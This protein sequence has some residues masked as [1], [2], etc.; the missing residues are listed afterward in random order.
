MR[1][2]Q[3]EAKKTIERIL[4][5]AGPGEWEVELSARTS[6]H[7]RF[8]RN[9]IG[10]SGFVEDVDLGVTARQDGRSGTVGTNDLSTAG[11]KAA[12]ARAAEMRDFMPVDPETVEMLP[13]Q[14]YPTLEKYDDATALARAADRAHGVKATLGLAQRRSLTSAGF[15]ENGVS[16][17][18]IGNS[19]GNFGYHLSTDAEF[20]VTMRTADGTGSGWAAGS[21]PRL[22]D[23]DAKSLARSAADKGVASAAPRDVPPG[24]YTVILEPAA[25]AALLQ[26]L[27]LG[28]LQARAA[29]EGRSVFSKQGGGSRVGEKVAH[30]SVTLRT[31]PFDAR[32]PGAPW[33]VRGGFG[34]GATDG[35]PN[36]RIAWIEKGVLK[37]LYAD[38]YWAGKTGVEATPFPG[39]LVLDGGKESLA[40]LIA[41]TERGLLVT[42]FWYIRTVNPQT[43][44]LTGLTR[45]GLFLIEKGK[46]THPATNLRF[47]ESPLVMLANV[48]G[49]TAAVPAGRMVVP[50]IRSR[51]FTFTSKSDAV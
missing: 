43:W 15:F 23:L 24:D 25:V 7:T 27:Q 11:L 19:R 1:W 21:S 20:S 22:R 6:S 10:T 9:E 33:S 31:D 50:A 45:D 28:A 35:L 37:T 18:A 47:N 3:G 41:G 32:L 38:R 34:E 5:L 39:S 8:A 16:H 12:L 42:R 30:E 29:D 2:D 36:R 4:S 49:M 17:R 46:I 51:E 14:K 48:E 13:V 40:A 44:Q 26:T